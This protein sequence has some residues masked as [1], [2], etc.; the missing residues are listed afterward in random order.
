MNYHR[1]K[2]SKT[3]AY[4][5]RFAGVTLVL[6]LIFGTGFSGVLSRGLQSVGAPLWGVTD[7][8]QNALGSVGA[9]LTTKQSLREENIRLK[10]NVYDLNLSLIDYDTLLEQN[11]SFRELL[12]RS[13][14]R[15][16]ILA[17]VITKP[18]R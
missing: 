14:G 4:V 5:L 15:S 11:F 10:E 17:S 3:I 7:G 9:L 6:F 1:N 2:E 8:A 18:S 16:S 13:Q 12:D